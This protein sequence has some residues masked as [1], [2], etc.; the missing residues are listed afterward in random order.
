MVYR[1][2]MGILIFALDPTKAHELI[3]YNS[4]TELY[5]LF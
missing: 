1:V 4:V 2:M 3:L 5:G